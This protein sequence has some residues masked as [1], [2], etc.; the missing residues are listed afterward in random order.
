MQRWR[1]PLGFLCGALFVLFARPRPLTLGLGGAIALLGLAL[2][3]WAAG[4]IRKNAELAVSGP[5]AYTR[6]PL[7]LGSFLLGIGFTVASGQP[8]LGL[9][10]AAL[11]LG[12]YLPVMRVESATLAGLFGEDYERYAGAVPLFIPRPWPYS[13]ARVPDVKFDASLYL[14]YREYRAALGLLIAWSLLALKAVLLK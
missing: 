10:F 8:L 6:N 9:L 1:V 4:H 3:A 12:I 11:F 7:Y 2:R 14:R 5:Y 13:D